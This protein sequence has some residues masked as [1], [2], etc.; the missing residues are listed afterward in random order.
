MKLSDLAPTVTPFHQGKTLKASTWTAIDDCIGFGMR[1]RVIMHHDTVMAEFH[2]AYDK[3]FH[4]FDDW[5]TKVVSVGWGSK[6]DA[7]GMNQLLLEVGSAMRMA[8]KNGT[9]NYVAPNGNIIEL[10]RY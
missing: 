5:T 7:D 2:S 6:S 9:A 10:P 3:D 8:R 1:R 4:E